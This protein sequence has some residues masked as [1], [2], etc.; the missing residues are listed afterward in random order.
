MQFLQNQFLNDKYRELAQKTN[1]NGLLKS[2]FSPVHSIDECDRLLQSIDLVRQEIKT[3]QAELI[4]AFATNEITK[5]IP[6]RLVRDSRASSDTPYLRW[7][8]YGGNT[9][10]DIGFRQYIVNLRQGE[11]GTLIANLL[12]AESIRVSLNMQMGII[13]SM[14]NQLNRAKETMVQ[15]AKIAP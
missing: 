2:V 6:M 15:V 3:I 13:H 9:H 5:T 1:L 8:N 10:G 14:L 11:H 12:Q 4:T 7:R